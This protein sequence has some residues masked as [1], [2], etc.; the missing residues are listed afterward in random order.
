[1]H[2]LILGAGVIG[3]TT[4]YE[5]LKAG[6]EVTVIDRQPEPALET[7]FGNAGLIAPGHSYAW[8]TP[9]LPRNLFKSL[10]EKKRAFR[11]KFQWDPA[12][13]YWGIQ[14]LRQCTYKNMAVNTLRKHRLCSYS[15]NC[16]HH[17]ID[18]TNISYHENK[19]GLIYFFRSKESFLEGKQ[20]LAMLKPVMNNLQ[21]L[22]RTEL[23]QLEPALKGTKAE[24]FGGIYCPTDESGS[25][26]DFTFKLGEIC[27]EK[28]VCFHFQTTILNIEKD[29]CNVK[30]IITDKG[31]FQADKYILAC[32]A[33]SPLIAKMVGDYLPIYPVKG[34]SIT[35][36]IIDY[37]KVP[38]HSGIDEDNLLAFSLLGDKI[39]FTSV[40]EISGYDTTHTPSDFTVMVNLTESLFPNAFDFSKI[41]YWAGLRPMPPNG[42]PILGT[43]KMKNLYFNTGHGH[44]G[45]TMCA[46]SAKITSHLISGQKPELDLEGMTLA[47]A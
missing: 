10:F 9:K 17:L 37:E 28:G 15:Q 7:S 2:I 5:L 34:Y 22:N 23:F 46:G 31:D 38:V 21:L 41:E 24:I 29:K 12:M 3:V 47:A 25:C 11:F 45:W 27:R 26:R 1:M 16:F 18:E 6:H 8:T 40:A 44:L 14:F 39:R 43:G 42:S 30:K 19:K 36:P 32:A 20:K 33:Y 13:W 4:A 35:V